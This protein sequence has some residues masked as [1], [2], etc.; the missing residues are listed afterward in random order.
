[1]KVADR[2]LYLYE[3]ML[4]CM[5]WEQRMLQMI[6]EGK[7]SGFFHAGRG[8]EGTQVGAIAALS[9]SDYLMYAHRGVGY[10]V[11]RGIPLAALFGDF[12]ANTAGTTRGLGA[13]IVHIAAPEL[14]VLGQS[15]TLGGCFPIAAGAALSAQYRG[16]TQ[17]CLCFFGD[18][19]ANRGTF[20]EAANAASVWKLPVVWLCENN[21]WA[22]SS[23][24]EETTSV[25]RIADRAASYGM[26]GETVDGQDAL[27]VYEAVA[28]A[29]ERCRRGEGPTLIE[30]ITYRF[31]AHYE[32][33]PDG[34]RNRNAVALI[35]QEKDPIL[36]MAA[37]LREAG[38]TDADLAAVATSVQERIAKAA[39]EAE[40]AA[41]PTPDRLHQFVWA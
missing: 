41:S 14:G 36:L 35:R 4:L 24:L 23:P 37:R 6:D 30:A 18:G 9:E 5:H 40:A 1:V 22:V 33:G 38:S 34:S 3:Q 15:G 11:A 13:G 7:V 27:A 8:Q 28:A 2:M 25:R 20:H 21:G 32:G 12:L 29:L 19:T 31:R 39:L 17:A 26:P 16:T 10:L